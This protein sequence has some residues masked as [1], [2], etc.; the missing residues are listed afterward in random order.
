[1]KTNY[2]NLT[3]KSRTSAQSSHLIFVMLLLILGVACDDPSLDRIE[4]VPAVEP[5]FEQVE[6]SSIEVYNSDTG[7]LESQ[8]DIVYD[9]RERIE[10]IVFS[11]VEATSYNFDYSQNNQVVSYE[12]QTTASTSSFSINYEDE[13]ISIDQVAGGDIEMEFTVDSE[14][15]IS[16]NLIEDGGS[17]VVDRRLQYGANNNVTREDFI[18]NN[19]LERFVTREHNFLINPFVDMNDIIRFIVFETFL[20]NSFYTATSETITQRIT[21]TDLIVRQADFTYVTENDLVTER[22]SVVAQG[23][24]TTTNRV[25]FNYRL[26]F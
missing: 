1:M 14:N 26:R 25:V 4:P 10:S 3:K 13:L 15:R 23:A 8:I 7:N 12:L 5:D 9:N 11:G 6:L 21:G 16:R 20:P 22:T 2:S 24:T 17:I 18:S 19:T